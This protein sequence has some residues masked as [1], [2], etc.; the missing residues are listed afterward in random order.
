MKETTS[1]FRIGNQTLLSKLALIWSAWRIF[2]HKMKSLERRLIMKIFNNTTICLMI[3]KLLRNQWRIRCLSS[4]KTYQ[5][6]VNL[7]KKWAWHRPTSIIKLCTL[8]VSHSPGILWRLL[9]SS[10]IT[11]NHLRSNSWQ[12]IKKA[13]IWGCLSQELRVTT[14]WIW[15]QTRVRTTLRYKTFWLRRIWNSGR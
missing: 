10:K 12:L 6:L 4:I 13:W 9:P 5:C 8:R 1:I 2:Y 11:Q 7:I 14:L 15:V 3:R